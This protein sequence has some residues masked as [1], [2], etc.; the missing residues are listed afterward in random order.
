VHH[1]RAAELVGQ[2]GERRED[3][4][5]RAARAEVLLGI[6]S[7]AALRHVVSRDLAALAPV[8]REPRG[9]AGEP[10]TQRAALVVLRPPPP[11]DE[12]DVLDGVLHVRARDA[13][14]DE[15]AVEVVDLGLEG[16]R[17]LRELWRFAA[18]AR[19]THAALTDG[20]RRTWVRPYL[21]RAMPPGLGRGRL[22]L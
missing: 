21:A 15:R 2:R 20:T 4:G 10:G 3:D 5:A 6:E 8:V 12:E 9:D 16:A 7:A 22:E 14:A 19:D 11:H 1:D 17:T 13:V 18:G